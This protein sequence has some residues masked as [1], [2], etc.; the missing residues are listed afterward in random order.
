MSEGE[1]QMPDRDGMAAEYVLGTLPHAERLAAEA[2]IAADPRFAAE[3]AAWEERLHP[4]TDDVAPVEPPAHL[5]NRIEARLFPTAR[6]TR[7]LFWPLWG[8]LVGALAVAVWLA[9]GPLL[10]LPTVPSVTAS[11]VADNQPLVIQAA[12]D[13]DRR[14][15]RVHRS[16]GPAAEPGKDYEL[17]V[18]P[19]G[20]K[21]VSLGLVRDGER[22]IP[23][24]ELPAGTTLAVTLE[25]AGGTPTGVAQGPILVAAVIGKG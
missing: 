19:A 5:R 8:A 13:A 7:R 6:A 24:A 9:F 20:Q 10:N 3:V 22:T 1:H 4:L 17:W 16:A 21:A 11:L 23:L 2:L 18:I 25:Q 14:E 15:L 12:Y